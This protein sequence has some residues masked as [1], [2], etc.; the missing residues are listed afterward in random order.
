MR[1]C[2]MIKNMCYTLRNMCKNIFNFTTVTAP[3]SCSEEEQFSQRYLSLELQLKRWNL[4]RT[5]GRTHECFSAFLS[6]V[7]VVILEVTLDNKDNLCNS[8]G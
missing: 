3:F 1:N 2:S 4:R 6:L 8:F 5:R 7:V